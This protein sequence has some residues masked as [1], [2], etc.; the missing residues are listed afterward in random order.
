LIIFA[1]VAFASST[2]GGGR[3]TVCN[4]FLPFPCL[5][6]TTPT[7][8]APVWDDTPSF[9]PADMGNNVYN[10]LFIDPHSGERFVF[11]TDPSHP[12]GND[13]AGTSWVTSS[14]S[15]QIQISKDGKY[16]VVSDSPDGVYYHTCIIPFDE[17]TFQAGTSTGPLTILPNGTFNRT[18]TDTYYGSDATNPFLIKSCDVSTGCAGYTNVVNL[19]SSSACPN[20]PSLTLTTQGE[21]SMSADG[22]TLSFWGDGNQNS[23]IIFWVYNKTKGCLWVNMATGDENASSGWG[24]SPST[25]SG[26]IPLA[27]RASTTPSL[28]MHRAN[29][30][31]LG[32]YLII[33]NQSVGGLNQIYQVPTSTSWPVSPIFHCTNASNPSDC[34]NHYAF[35]YQDTMVNGA[36]NNGSASNA[37]IA[38]RIRNVGSTMD[39]AGFPPGYV[40]LV[41]TI[42]IGAIPTGNAS[43]ESWAAA[44]PNVVNPFASGEYMNA[45]GTSHIT[46]PWVQ[47]IKLVSPNPS[48]QIVW[49]I[50]QHHMKSQF[51]SMTENGGVVG[52][53]ATTTVTT[54]GPHNFSAGQKIN[55]YNCGNSSFNST[56][57]QVASIISTTTFTYSSALVGTTDCMFD[58]N[59]Q[60]AQDFYAS[61]LVQQSPDGKF[62]CTPDNWERTFPQD[63][64]RAACNG[65]DCPQIHML[66]VE[67]R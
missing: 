25:C 47:E 6:P 41:N 65:T 38:W 13:P 63:P 32:D 45:T 59:A 17:T 56:S 5:A 43:H 66:C 19:A 23:A 34:Q 11:I 44:D 64:Y 12:C 16:I 49:R 62:I 3:S 46:F 55:I 10:H 27:D 58:Y 48:N 14:Y 50:F 21:V 35:G 18:E 7:S 20:I 2:S 30:T 54:I 28:G 57:T 9:L 15:D 8:S 53:G 22:Q 1:N 52:N 51:G 37:I 26:C 42:A 24:L 67:T 31:A 60:G 39:T 61:T 29:L 36:G 4:G 33:Q 40:D